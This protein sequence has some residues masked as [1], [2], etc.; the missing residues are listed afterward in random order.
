MVDI[1]FFS[2]VDVAYGRWLLEKW[3]LGQ[4]RVGRA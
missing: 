2:S 4:D 3:G 1:Q